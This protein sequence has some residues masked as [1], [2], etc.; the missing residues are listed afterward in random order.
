[1]HATICGEPDFGQVG[2]AVA[3][4]SSGV[5]AGYAGPESMTDAWLFPNIELGPTLAT[6]IN[7]YGWVIGD[8]VVSTGQSHVQ[9]RVARLPPHVEGVSLPWIW[10][11]DSGIVMLPRFTT[12]NAINQSGQIVGAVILSDGS[13]HGGLLTGN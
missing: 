12:A 9:S 2:A 4:N 5:T 8:Q 10:S 3:I 6:G 1:M 7:D 13:T 11:Q